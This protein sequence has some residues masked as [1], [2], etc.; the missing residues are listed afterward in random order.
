MF[1]S[2]YRIS[3][4]L[5]LLTTISLYIQAEVLEVSLIWNSDLCN[6]K[7][8]ELLKKQ[9]GKAKE[10]ESFTMN[11]SS[12]TA[13]IKWNPQFPFSYQIVKSHLQMVGVGLS[14][15]RVRVRGKALLQGERVA[16]LSEGDNTLFFLISPVRASPG[17]YTATPAGVLVDLATDLKQKILTTAAEGKVIVVE[18]PLYQGHRS[19]PLH[20]IVSRLQI[21]KK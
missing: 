5:S 4:I 12:G 2:K 3:L 20:L 7:C 13:S 16:L 9:F 14:Q 15:M 17:E 6:E 19:P 18:G 8:T 10:I 11:S 21:E 1:F